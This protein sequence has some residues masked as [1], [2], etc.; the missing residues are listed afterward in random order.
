MKLPLLTLLLFALTLLLG[1]AGCSKKEDAAPAT[2]GSYKFNGE[3]IKC[4][5]TAKIDPATSNGQGFDYLDLNFTTVPQPASGEE[6]M[7]I[8]LYKQA[9][10]AKYQVLAMEVN[11]ARYPVLQG[12][13][14][15]NDSVTV[16]TTHSG[17][18]S[19]TF[20]GKATTSIGFS[21]Q[22]DY[23]F[24]EGVFTDVRP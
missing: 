2:N 12:R 11:T 16:A 8:Y 19:G 4:W 17:D 1:T 20:S 9:S 3:L 10:Q 22:K 6:T 5:V 21:F 23:L 13:G 15:Y 18:F 14:L 24:T 7:K